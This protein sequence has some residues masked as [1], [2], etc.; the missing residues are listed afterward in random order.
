MKPVLTKCALLALAALAAGCA[1]PPSSIAPVAVSTSNYD[2][3]SCPQLSA[4]ISNNARELAESERR[5]RNA[6]AG[7]AV[8]VALILIPPSAFTGDASADVALNK[9]EDLAMRQAYA[10]RCLYY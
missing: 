6:V 1:K 9:G 3:Y 8:G 10:S 5:Q 2:A 4:A 7:D